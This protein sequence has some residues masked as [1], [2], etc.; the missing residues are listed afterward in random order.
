MHSYL[1]YGIVSWG[2]ATSTAL[3]PLTSLVNRIVRI[4]TFAP[5]GNIDVDSIYKY[6]DVPK[7]SD[8]ISIETGKFIFRKENDLL[9]VVDIANHFK[10]RNENVTHNYN[11]RNRNVNM[12]PI[13][14]TS[15][16]GEKSVQYRGAQLW[17]SLPQSTRPM[18]Q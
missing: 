17:N 2:S 15:S 11:L 7:V 9:P 1:R 12:C 18:Q 13:E 8:I 5:F 3:Q 14:Y 16:F 4:M 6:L 10:L